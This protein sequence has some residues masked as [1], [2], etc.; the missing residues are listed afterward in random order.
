MENKKQWGS[1]FIKCITLL[2]IT[3]LNFLRQIVEK[4]QMDL[5]VTAA[6]AVA[7]IILIS[8]ITNKAIQNIRGNQE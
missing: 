5:A 7:Y 2:D 8:V 3:M 4:Y 1:V 6:I